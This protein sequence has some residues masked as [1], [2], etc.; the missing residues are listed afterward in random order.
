MTP[1]HDAL[2]EELRFR[3]KVIGRIYPDAKFRHTSG[4]FFWDRSQPAIVLVI[5]HDRDSHGVHVDEEM[6]LLLRAIHEEMA[7][8]MPEREP[9]TKKWPEHDHPIMQQNQMFDL[10][11]AAACDD[12]LWEQDYVQDMHARMMGHQPLDRIVKAVS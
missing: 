12:A 8:T 4:G 10:L 9:N 5:L 11:V 6:S 1:R 3:R 2:W 7:H